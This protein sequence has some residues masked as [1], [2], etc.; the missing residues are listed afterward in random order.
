MGRYTTIGTTAAIVFKKTLNITSNVNNYNLYNAAVAAGWPPAKRIRLTLNIASGVTV[1]S[2]STSI[3]ALDISGFKAVDDITVI[4]SGSILGKGGAGGLGGTSTSVNGQPG[5]P[6]GAAI[7]VVSPSKIKLTNNGVIGGGSGGNGGAGAIRN[8][9]YRLP[10]FWRFYYG[11]V[12]S[13]PGSGCQNCNH[14]SLGCNTGGCSDN[15]TNPGNTLA[16]STWN[17]YVTNVA[18]RNQQARG[19]NY[20]VQV[21]QGWT[22][23]NQTRFTCGCGCD[24]RSITRS[25]RQGK[26]T[27]NITYTMYCCNMCIVRC[28][29]FDETLPGAN[30]AAG[31]NGGGVN[32][33]KGADNSYTGGAGGTRGNYF[34]G[35]AQITL[36]NNGTLRG[37]VS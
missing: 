26:S 22:L 11:H 30:G 7:R 21:R 28:T 19:Y 23:V 34:V 8:T 6:G 14:G 36:R 16:Q 15:A 27:R 33:S 31:A 5:Q 13:N 29:F 37:G 20:V 12:W 32:G 25:I 2:T 4:N 1:G 9:G 3:P 35:N 24:G 18:Y 17:L 10:C